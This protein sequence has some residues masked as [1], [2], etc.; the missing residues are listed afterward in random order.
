MIIHRVNKFFGIGV[1]HL[2]VRSEI[3]VCYNVFAML[4]STFLYIYMHV[5]HFYCGFVQFY[6]EGLVCMRNKKL[7]RHKNIFRWAFYI[8]YVWMYVFISFHEFILSVPNE[9]IKFYWKWAC[10]SDLKLI[11]RYQNNWNIKNVIFQYFLWQ[12]HLLKLKLYSQII[13]R[14]FMN[15]L[16]NLDIIILGFVFRNVFDVNQTGKNQ[17]KLPG[18][19][20]VI[21]W[22]IRR[23]LQIIIIHLPNYASK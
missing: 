10:I 11:V 3:N 8:L 16:S 22:L 9:N 7:R 6:G 4:R 13:Q 21:P 5:G 18:F 17:F 1:R 19:D 20:S 15:S 12:I 2:F 14:V 23:T